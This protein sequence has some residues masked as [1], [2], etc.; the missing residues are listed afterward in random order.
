MKY[1]CCTIGYICCKS[2]FIC[3]LQSYISCLHSQWLQE[4][5]SNYVTAAF[6][7]YL[8]HTQ[9]CSLF[10]DVNW[11]I[12]KGMLMGYIGLDIQRTVRSCVLHY[13]ILNFSMGQGIELYTW[14]SPLNPQINAAHSSEDGGEQIVF[15]LLGECGKRDLKHA[16]AQRLRGWSVRR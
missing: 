12:K 5:Y 7:G 15:L 13:S 16:Y 1:Q 4:C 14:Q 9:H 2:D 10:E 11:A 3:V 6:A 8:F